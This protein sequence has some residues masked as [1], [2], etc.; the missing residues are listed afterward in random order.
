MI[1]EDLIYKSFAN[2]VGD[3]WA[4]T[5]RAVNIEAFIK[6]LL[7][8]LVKARNFYIRIARVPFPTIRGGIITD[9]LKTSEELAEDIENLERQFGITPLFTDTLEQRALVVEAQWGLTG[10]QG[11]GY[12]QNALTNAGIPVVVK[13]NLPAQ[14]LTLLASTQYG[15]V[16]YGQNSYGSYEVEILGNGIIT[17]DNISNDPVTE[18]DSLEK[19]ANCFIVESENWLV[20]ATLNQSQYNTLKFLLLK[21][22]PADKVVLMNV[23]VI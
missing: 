15:Q 13:E 7:S 1:S 11:R 22:K 8:V 19:W 18:M 20:P 9:D 10:S 6:S 14:D 5:L 4:W 23:K 2:L 17:L 12:L 16:Q 21:L 3:G